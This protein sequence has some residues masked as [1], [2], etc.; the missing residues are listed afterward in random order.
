MRD[1]SNGGFF[2]IDAAPIIAA[3]ETG[4]KIDGIFEDAKR[5]IE[6]G[7]VFVLTNIQ[8]EEG[9]TS[10]KLSGV[11]ATAGFAGTAIQATVTAYGAYLMMITN[12]DIITI[13][14]E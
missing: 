1:Y 9:G 6:G 3:G 12:E 7:K 5:A 4:L 13:T 14:A 8:L 10:V 2:F 11:F